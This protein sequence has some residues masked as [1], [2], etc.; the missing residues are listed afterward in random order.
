VDQEHG[1]NSFKLPTEASSTSVSFEHSKPRVELVKLVRHDCT[2]AR[3]VFTTWTKLHDGVGARMFSFAH[4]L[5]RLG[6]AGEY[7]G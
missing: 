4:L 7:L 3:G 1:G 2:S 5:E 6:G